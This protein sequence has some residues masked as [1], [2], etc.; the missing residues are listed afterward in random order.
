MGVGGGCN[1]RCGLRRRRKL[2]CV[3]SA[4]W[5]VFN[6]DVV[7]PSVRCAL[8]VALTDA[9]V[10]DEE[11]L[12][13]AHKD[14]TVCGG[15]RRSGRLWWWRQAADKLPPRSEPRPVLAIVL[16]G[17]LPLSRNKA[18]ARAGEVIRVVPDSS[19]GAAA[20][21]RRKGGAAYAAAG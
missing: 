6:A 19:T 1:C 7:E 21:R 9:M 10:R 4:R 11:A 17:G 14:K 8:D 20:R 18:V 2:K 13:P 16:D 3:R 15:K 12:F 5:A